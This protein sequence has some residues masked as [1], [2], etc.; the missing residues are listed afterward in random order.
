MS[1]FLSSLRGVADRVFNGDAG[2]QRVRGNNAQI[3]QGAEYAA[4][5][6]NFAGPPAQRGFSLQQSYSPVEDA[7][8]VRAQ[9]VFANDVNPDK[10]LL[11][12]ARDTTL[13]VAG[14]FATGALNLAALAGTGVSAVTPGSYDIGVPIGQFAEDTGEWIG[15]LRTHEA[16]NAATAY[17]VTQQGLTDENRQE[18]LEAVGRGDNPLLAG[19]RRILND[20]LDSGGQVLAQPEALGSGIAQGIGSLLLGGPTSKVATKTATLAA[21]GLAA[22]GLLSPAAARAVAES[23]EHG[24]MTGTIAAMEGGGAYAQA[25]GQVMASS[26]EDLLANSPQYASLIQQGWAPDRAKNAI[27]SRAGGIAAAIQA[28]IAAATGSMVA[29]FEAAPLAAQTVRGAL[30]NVGKEAIEEGVQSFS[31]TLSSNV[32]VKLTGNVN[33]DLGEGVGQGLAEG[34]IFGAGTA[35]AFAG[36]AIG[37]G[38]VDRVPRAVARAADAIQE[39]GRAINEA[40]KITPEQTGEAVARAAQP[41]GAEPFVPAQT[42][43]PVADA[44]ELDTHNDVLQSLGQTFQ[45]DPATYQPQNEAEVAVI[46][47]LNAEAGVDVWDVMLGASNAIASNETTPEQKTDLAIMIATLQDQVTG[48]SFNQVLDLQKQAVPGGTMAQELGRIIAGQEAIA[49]NPLIRKAL[50]RAFESA[51]EVTVEAVEDVSTPEGQRAAKQAA[52]QAV[53]TPENIRPEVVDRLLKHSANSPQLF[54]PRQV[55]ALRTTAALTQ[56]VQAMEADAQRMGVN[57]P[58]LAE[59]AKQAQMYDDKK[60]GFAGPSVR[61]HYAEVSRLMGQG[62]TDEA[63]EALTNFQNF[64]QSMANK[65]EAINASHLSRTN[66]VN[67]PQTFDSY[68]QANGWHKGRVEV[69]SQV[70]G[71][72][73]FAQQAGVDA[74]FVVDSYNK[75]TEQYPE[76]G[77]QKVTRQ[78][79]NADLTAGPA[80]FVAEQTLKVR[81]VQATKAVTPPVTDVSPAKTEDQLKATVATEKQQTQ[82][83]PETAPVEQDE[84]LELPL[85]ARLL[86]KLDGIEKSLADLRRERD[87]AEQALID[88]PSVLIEDTAQAALVSEAE[89]KPE[90][91]ETI[92]AAPV[93]QKKT[94]SIEEVFPNVI[95]D[96]NGDQLLLNGF[97]LN[98]EGR[99]RLIGENA[100]TVEQIGAALQSPEAF[101]ELTG[102][103]KSK[104]SLPVSAAYNA[105]FVGVLTKVFPKMEERLATSKNFKPYVNGADPSNAIRRANLRLLNILNRGT[106]G[107]LSIDPM[108]GSAMALAMVDWLAQ[109]AVSPTFRTE[110]DIARKLK[111][112][113]TEVTPELHKAYNSSVTSQLAHESLANTLKQFL[114]LKAKAD[115]KNGFTDGL[116]MSMAGELLDAAEAAGLVD[117][118]PKKG[119]RLVVGGKDYVFMKTSKEGLGL[120][121]FEDG[122]PAFAGQTTLVSQTVLQDASIAGYTLGAPSGN[123]LTVLQGGGAPTT[124]EQNTAAKAENAVAQTVN[125]P[126]YELFTQLGVDGVVALFGNGT[127][128]ETMNVNDRE[129][130]EGQNLAFISAYETMMGMAQELQAYADENGISLEEAKLY[131]EYAYSSVN[132]L[133]QQGQFGD[134]AS[135]LTR[136]MITPYASTL[137]MT[138]PAEAQMWRR[139]IAQ[140]L[141]VKVEKLRPD[142]WENELSKALAKSEVQAAIAALADENTPA[143]QLIEVLQAA[144]VD[145]PVK[146]HALKSVAEFQNLDDPKGFFTHMYV[147]ADGVTDGPT[148][149]LIYMRLKGFTSEMVAGLRRGGLLFSKRASPL[150]ETFDPEVGEKALDTYEIGAQRLVTRLAKS[151]NEVVGSGKAKRDQDALKAQSEALLTVM[152]TLLGGEQFEHDPVTGAYKIGRKQLK[153]PLTVTVYGS[154]PSGIAAK[155]AKEMT[156]VFYSEVS[157]ANEAA[158]TQGGTYINHLLGGLDQSAEFREAIKL[159]GSNSVMKYRDKEEDT[160]R[161]YVKQMDNDVIQNPTDGTKLTIDSRAEKNIAKALEVFYVTPMV[162]AIN[163]GMGSSVDGS[164]L[165]QKSTGIMSALAKTAFTHAIQAELEKQKTA[166][167]SMSE[168]LSPN[169]LKKVLSRVAFL[170]PYMEGDTIT[171]NVK[172]LQKGLMTAEGDSEVR[173]SAT[174]MNNMPTELTIP[175]PALAGVAGAAYVNISYGD[176]RMIIKAS[177]ALK[178]GRL[179]VFDG[180][181]LALKDAMSNGKAINETVL[182]ALQSGTPFQDLQKTF[183]TMVETID[184]G[185]FTEA[186]MQEVFNDITPMNFD[187][188]MPNIDYVSAQLGGLKG[189][190]ADAVLDEKARQAVLAK[191]HLSSDHMAA[192]GAPA[193]TESDADRIDL[194]GMSPEEQAATLEAM[195]QTERAKLEGKRER[196]Q[197]PNEDLSVALEVLKPETSG[198]RLTDTNRLGSLL[199]DL[200]IP[201]IQKNLLKRALAALQGTNWKV[202]FGNTNQV[203][204]FAEQESI[205]FLFQEGDL[206]LAAVGRKTIIVANQSSETLAHELIHAAT[207]DRLVAYFADPMSVDQVSRDA[208]LRLQGLM[209]DW[210]SNAPSAALLRNEKTR[211]AVYRAFSAVDEL[212]QQGKDAEALNE[213]MAWNLANQDLNKLNSSIKIE[214]KLAQIAKK[215]ANV[216]RK[217]FNL[218][219]VGSDIAS[220]LQ[221]NAAILMREGMPSIQT[222]AAERLLMQSSRTRPDLA[223]ITRGFAGIV[224]TADAGFEKFYGP[225]PSEMALGYGQRLAQTAKNNGFPMTNEEQRAF[226]QVIAA[227]RANRV[228][229]S[230]ENVRMDAYSN[231]VLE[232]M[233]QSDMMS[234]PDSQ[235][236]GEQILASQRMDLLNGTLDVGNDVN[237]LTLL[238]PMF[239]ALGATNS[240]A[241]QLFSRIKVRNKKIAVDGTTADS[242]V[243]SHAGRVFNGLMDHTY[244]MKPDQKVGEEIQKLVASVIQQHE[245]EKG[246][247]TQALEAP[248]NVIRE[249]NEKITDMVDVSIDKATEGLDFLTAQA[250]GTNLESFATTANKVVQGAMGVMSKRRVADSTSKLTSILNQMNMDQ[251]FRAFASELMGVN[252]TNVDVLRL[253]KIARATIHRVRQTYRKLMPQQIVD[254][255]SRKLSQQE[256]NDLHVGLGQTDA[257]VLLN[258]GLSSGAVVDLFSD[259][260]EMKRL[261]DQKEA[262]IRRL[263]GADAPAILTDAADLAFLMREG[264]P[265]HG[266]TKRNALAIAN[267]AGDAKVGAFSLTSPEV[268]AVDGFV[269][270]LSMSQVAPSVLKTLSGLAASDREALADVLSLVAHARDTEMERVPDRHRF[271]VFKGYMPYE[272]QGSFKSVP[273]SRLNEYTKAGYNI[274][275]SR[276]KGSVEALYDARSSERVYVATDLGAPS[277]KQGIMQTVRSTVFGLDATTGLQHDNPTAGMISD[278]VIVKQITAALKKNRQPEGLAPL[279][280]EQG[281]IYAYE[282]LVDK[283]DAD[284]AIET[285][286][287]AAVSL[288]QWMGRQ[289]EERQ[290]DAL[291]DVLIERLANMWD[292]AGRQVREDE[293]VDLYELGEADP[294]VADALRLI[295]DRDRSR[296][297]SKM[298]GKFMVRKD[299][300]EQIIGYR[301][302]SVGDL[303]TGNT[304][305]QEENRDAVAN[306]LTG[307]LGPETYRR[308]TLAE[309]QWTSLMGDARVA[310]VVK[311]VLVPMINGIANFYQLMANGIGPVDIAKMSAEKLR[312]TH[313]YAQN[314]LKYQE[315]ENKLA[316]AKGAKRPD[317]IRLLETEMRKIEDLNKRLTIWPL[318][319]AGEFTQVTEGLTQDDMEMSRGRMWDQ[320]SKWAD[321]L[322]PAMKTAGRY[323][324]VAKDTALFEGLARTVAYTDFVAKSVLYEHLTT[325]GKLTPDQAYLRITNEFVNYDLLGGRMRSKAEEVGLIWFWSF[326]LRSIKVAASMIRNNPLHALLTTFAPGVENVGTVL[327]DNMLG[328][329]ADGRW[330]NSLGPQNAF[331]ALSLNPISQMM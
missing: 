58:K 147:E 28:P 159:L 299:M 77:L 135:K 82:P 55:T 23:M 119:Q 35:G 298:G 123:R 252:E 306:Y 30:Q 224:A 315:L 9:N 218:P 247:L 309:N 271:N 87:I 136:E 95:R 24:A 6:R 226:I 89:A 92:E 262:D 313:L 293:F 2:T 325:K 152:R 242:W 260:A 141:G 161:H 188:Q 194:G 329:I 223:E 64:A 292:E 96:T 234:D 282:R 288:G 232:Q 128:S 102:M 46:A 112:D 236:P 192:L 314:H 178:G 227:F 129:A 36:P 48:D 31:G 14:G 164:E 151:I 74:R 16:Q 257:A 222:I 144:G 34:A 69:R 272:R 113:V 110:E 208:I 1:D 291:N 163:E 201:G 27:A 157:A 269:S 42:V 274:V 80:K 319:A 137:D 265:P 177:P 310:I 244:G 245:A 116:L 307:L 225:R 93:E 322:P 296:V 261:K 251:E 79:L 197:A 29:R 60:A 171:V 241:Q 263:F 273:V 101:A 246:L 324:V 328:L 243:K 204:A 281:Q 270:L 63:K 72:V 70:P 99:T 145:A 52:M 228:R 276:K 318:I 139:G 216:L 231:E 326:K 290:A 84:Q 78:D 240:T 158:K 76:L 211:D 180:I 18:E 97:T 118:F 294:V 311:S 88:E 253:V 57:V 62:S 143:Q 202:A 317:R 17:A 142:N 321:R 169:E 331:R 289:H 122:G 301:S 25:S 121:K 100:I 114:G 239:V 304:R 65:M 104:I 156:R 111:I 181:N 264:K 323:A 41:V 233:N 71:S 160:A 127:L 210:L 267:R 11:A 85:D 196:A 75:L 248:A 215:V 256:W 229:N 183:D 268:Q 176:G 115:V 213:F 45:F 266:L 44:A 149:S 190:L 219:A 167:G 73:A 140:A 175:T 133:Q 217:M 109:N 330:D 255:F 230:K 86:A 150:H 15:G 275:G 303:W 4:A 278:P 187:A 153:N 162:A 259:A 83:E 38:V 20:V 12:Q 22:R 67:T 49:D 184:L 297:L 54:T 220:N 203:N 221:F 40:N 277:F 237:G 279:F 316:A 185:Q 39:R 235:D 124:E 295:N 19:G 302:I 250:K 165:I 207:I 107:K 132:R 174:F 193:S 47:G 286:R 186:E 212:L 300:Y 320:V 206:G 61:G 134:Q 209:T 170:F 305:V 53:L 327:D 59:V 90:A 155:I 125:R 37:A 68:S 182:S 21:E 195:F 285:Q 91:S 214:S 108:I 105:A 7:R 148:N 198:V 94:P 287:N 284:N 66:R 191:V 199:E 254:T 13:D 205:P 154:S 81:D 117:V 179:M 146:L 43:D 26:H 280:N 33:Q 258:Q 56:T 5:A 10:G 200:N 126:M 131:R 130:K 189:R 50:L 106:D 238:V 51:P 3:R 8:T 308:L 172:G 32:G 168:G 283:A 103:A 138:N 166:G 312:E 98:N 249:A 120:K 173:T